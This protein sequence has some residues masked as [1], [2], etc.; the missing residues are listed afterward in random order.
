[1]SEIL[2]LFPDFKPKALPLSYDDGSKSDIK[3][4]EILNKYGIK[5]TFNLNSGLFGKGSRISADQVVKLYKNHEIAAHGY[6]HP[7]YENLDSLS[8]VIDIY[9]DRKELEKLTGNI[10]N[11]MAYPFGIRERE[12][13]SRSMKEAGILYGRTANETLSFG[14]P[15]NFLLWDPTCHGTDKEVDRLIDEFL[16]PTDWKNLRWM[17]AKLFFIWG[18][19]CE[20]KDNWERL[21]SICERLSGL[22]DVWYA[23][24]IEIMRYITAYRS[25]EFSAQGN[26]LFNPSNIELFFCF[27]GEK[28]LLKPNETLKLY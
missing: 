2:M 18:H 15:E 16:K 3:M 25:I 12:K 10:V 26:I 27:D 22:D 20:F 24:N 9:E 14:I 7:L 23:T 19:S 8:R 28:V 17:S 5:C 6:N 13:V 4:I 21:E 1:M 11:G